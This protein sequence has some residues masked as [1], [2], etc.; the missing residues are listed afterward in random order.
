MSGTPTTLERL[1]RELL[2]ETKPNPVFLLG[3]GASV[4]S[5]VPTA[6]GFSEMIA[7]W[8]YLKENGRD[9]RDQNV[10]RSDWLPW[11]KR[12]AWYNTGLPPEV[13]YPA[14]VEHLLTPR[15]ARMRFLLERV[16]TALEPVPAT[17]HWPS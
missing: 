12:F 9:E 14:L 8:A 1:K 15:E 7:R 3:A 6:A 2:D 4:K 11:L 13:Q 5:G 17:S 10:H 16:R